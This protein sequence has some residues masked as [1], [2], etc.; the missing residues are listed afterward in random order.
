MLRYAG[1]EEKTFLGKVLF[2]SPCTPSSFS[3][4]FNYI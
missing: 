1:G 3:K 4:P 2:F